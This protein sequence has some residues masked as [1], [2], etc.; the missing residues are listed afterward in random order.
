GLP[1]AKSFVELHGGTLHIKSHPGKGTKVTVRFPASRA[2][3]R[4]ID[5]A[6]QESRP[7]PNRERVAISV[8]KP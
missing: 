2:I 3:A 5:C 1:L 8:S 6:D 7:S 4:A